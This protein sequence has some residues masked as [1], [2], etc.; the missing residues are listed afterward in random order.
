[1]LPLTGDRKPFLFIFRRRFDEGQATL[2]PSG[3]LAAYTSNESGTYHVIVR[4]FPDASAE[5][6]QISTDG[7]ALASLEPRWSVLVLRGG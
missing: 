1:M 6:L 7:G 5:K 2:S 3:Q 4:S